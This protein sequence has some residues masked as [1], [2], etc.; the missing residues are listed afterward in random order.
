MNRAIT[1]SWLPALTAC[2]HVTVGTISPPT[3]VVPSAGSPSRSAPEDGRTRIDGSMKI[4]HARCGMRG[5]L[6]SPS[7]VSIWLTGTPTWTRPSPGV[8]W[9]IARREFLH[10]VEDNSPASS[11]ETSLGFAQNPRSNRE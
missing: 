5:W 9:T 10:Q 7:V 2:A 4:V 11:D 8:L 1:G 6:A 3:I